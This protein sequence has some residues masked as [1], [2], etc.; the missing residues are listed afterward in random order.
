MDA[1]SYYVMGSSWL[2]LVSWIVM[3]LVAGAAVFRGDLCKS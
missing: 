3:L 1:V 2:F